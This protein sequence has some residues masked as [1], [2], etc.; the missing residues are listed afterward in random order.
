[1]AAWLIPALKAV[2]PH[3]GTIIAAAAPVFTRKQGDARVD[4]EVMQQQIEELQVAAS[5]NAAHVKE[6]AAQL[7]RTVAALEQA[8]T[9]AEERLKRVYVICGLAIA[10][11]VSA[12]ALALLSLA[13]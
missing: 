2:L 7:Q 10:A 4:Q 13:R 12:I 8:A 6:L 5:R 1:M 9:V 11:S 3:V